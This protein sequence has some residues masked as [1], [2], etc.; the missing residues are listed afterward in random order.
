MKLSRKLLL[1]ILAL[2]LILAVVWGY[3]PKPILVDVAP[4]TRGPLRVTIEE[5]GRTR[6]KD[7][8][9]VSAPIAGF[10][11]RIEFKVGDRLSAGQVV[12]ELEPP[13]T[14]ALD[15]RTRARAEARAQAAEAAYSAAKERIGVARA[16][17][18]YAQARRD[19]LRKL[20]VRGSAAQDELDQAEAQARQT[21]A[22]LAAAQAAGQTARFERDEALAVL[23]AYGGEAEGGQPRP[24]PVRAPVEGRV[25]KVLRQSAGMVA[26]GM[27]LLEL[28]DPTSLEVEV[29]V[30]SADAV[31]ISPGIRVAFQRWGGPA[32]LEGRVRLVEPYA[33][34]KVS[35]L[36]VEEQRVLVIADLTS[37]REEWVRLGDG[38]RVEAVFYIWEGETVLQA[39]ASAL[40]RTSE[41]WASFVFEADQVRRRLVRLGHHGGIT[42]EIVSGL[43]EG[44]LVV[45]HPDD[46]LADGA[47]VRREIK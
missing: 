11:R 26:P 5:E 25:L 8:F 31:R 35:A 20:T 3:R 27:P 18:E 32:A 22:T 10:A 39:P 28:G 16:E 21:Q 19:R 36:G 47:R 43:K 12:C 37:S 40:F 24:L 4:V 17:A 13:R 33:F 23:A 34:T 14:E 44:D 29:D 41:G 38:Y 46:R 45:V 30:L 6:V 2:A 9:L 42:A 7:R 1:I 15:S